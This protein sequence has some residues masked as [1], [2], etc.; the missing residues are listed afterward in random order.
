MN[1]TAL[2]FLEYVEWVLLDCHTM[3]SVLAE[4][5]CPEL[6]SSAILSKVPS[7]LQPV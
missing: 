6:L 4:W 3:L 5:M 7:I 2:V 1:P